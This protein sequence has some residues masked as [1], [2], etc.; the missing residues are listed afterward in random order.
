MPVRSFLYQYDLSGKTL[1]PFI[2]H[3]GSGLG[4]TMQDLKTFQPNA[5]ILDGVAIRGGNAKYGQR[6]VQQWLKRL[7]MMD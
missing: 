3:E 1:V 7:G 6:E 4:R 5:T 2:T